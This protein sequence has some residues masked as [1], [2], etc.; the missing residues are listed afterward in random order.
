MFFAHYCF[1]IFKVLQAI[2]KVMWK[3]QEASLCFYSMI[4]MAFPKREIQMI[5]I[6]SVWFSVCRKRSLSTRNRGTFLWQTKCISIRELAAQHTQLTFEA[7]PYRNS[8]YT[9]IYLYIYVYVRVNTNLCSCNSNFI[10]HTPLFAA[11]FVNS[12]RLDM[13]YYSIFYCSAK[14]KIS[15]MSN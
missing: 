11:T 15:G 13:Q 7:Q 10:F 12:I 1:S 5:W 3:Y 14:F 6:H 9:Y 8:I 2:K 4:F